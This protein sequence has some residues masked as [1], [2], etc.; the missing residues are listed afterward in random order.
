M[1]VNSA[2]VSTSLNTTLDA[3]KVLADA[4]ATSIELATEV[5][6]RGDADDTLQTNIDTEANTR[7]SAVVTLESADTQLQTNVDLLTTSTDADFVLDRARI[8]AIE[9]LLGNLQSVVVEESAAAPA[10]AEE[11]APF[12]AETA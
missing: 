10:E 1:Y 4:A 8:D 11:S 2:A 5:Q 9:A 3:L 7:G 12:P 6:A